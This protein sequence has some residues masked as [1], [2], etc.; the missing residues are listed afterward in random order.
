VSI[1]NEYFQKLSQQQKRQ[2]TP[3]YELHSQTG[4][5]HA[6]TICRKLIIDNTEFKAEALNRKLADQQ[7][8]ELAIKHFNIPTNVKRSIK[9]TATVLID[10]TVWNGSSDIINITLKKS[11]GET[12]EFKKLVAKIQNEQEL[13]GEIQ[14]DL[15]NMLRQQNVDTE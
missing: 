11:N 9:Y 12:Q 7:C 1:V 5:S 14:Y 13:A 6:P 15:R 4:P 2:I 8:A 10:E 3:K